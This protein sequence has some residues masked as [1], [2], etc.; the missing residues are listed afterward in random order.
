MMAYVF[1]TNAFSQL[2]HSYY[3]NRFPTLWQ[4]F[5]DL[6]T[7]GSITST[8]EAF[9]EIEDDRVVA[10]REWA[11][12]HRELFPAPTAE[13]AAFVARIF[14]VGH[15]QQV[16]EQKK[17]YKGG[18]NADPFIIARAAVTG[19]TVVTMESE[20]KNGAKIPNI[21]RHFSIPCLSLEG[22]MEEEGWQF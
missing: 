17:L 6:I 19:G 4:N 20:P 7:D 12:N 5:D 9:R 2:F 10:L 8:R 21:C 22:F 14:A 15:F 13:E 16:I 3:R 1:D 11:P 18:K